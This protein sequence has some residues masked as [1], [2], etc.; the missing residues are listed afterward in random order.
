LRRA[1]LA[2]PHPLV[3]PIDAGRPAY[4]GRTMPHVRRNAEG[5]LISLHRDAE[6][7]AD[8]FL[9]DEHPEVQAFVGRDGSGDGFARLDADFIRVLE[10]LID[11]LIRAKVINIT[12][13]PIEARSKLYSR[14]GHRATSSL[15]DLNLLGDQT[16][17]SGTVLPDF[18]ALR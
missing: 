2:A 3:V 6:P 7:G 14:K 9:P 15:S 13:L 4:S 1:E 10:D 17:A 11:V 12:D 5:A 18:G 8:E 16:G